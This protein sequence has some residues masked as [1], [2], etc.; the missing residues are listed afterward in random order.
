[1][2][3]K[4]KIKLIIKDFFRLAI[5]IPK[6]IIV[7]F[8][9]FLSNA[10]KGF[11]NRLRFSITFKI[12]AAF[13]LMIIS[14]FLFLSLIIV[15]GF[16]FYL[17]YNCKEDMKKDDTLI[18]TYLNNNIDSV[19]EP[20]DKIAK[21]KNRRISIFDENH[22][23]IFS[24][25]NQKDKGVYYTKD[26]KMGDG[27]EKYVIISGNKV[28]VHF[29]DTITPSSRFFIVLDESIKLD[30]TVYSI[31]YVDKLNNEFMYLGFFIS[32]LAV[33]SILALINTLITGWKAGK[34]MLKPIDNMSKT[35]KNITVNAL[36]TRINVSGSQDE[37]K[38]LAHTFNSML[39]RIQ[40]SYEQQN[41]FVSDASHELR[42]PI[43]VIQGYANL[44]DRWGKNDKDVLEE[45]I[46]A[47][48][49]EAE[50]MKGLIEQ[51]LFLARG[52]KNTQKIEK[53]NFYINELIDELIKETKLI[54]ERHKILTERNED[55]QI[56]AD[57]NLIKEALRIFIDNS[58]KYTGDGGYVKINSFKDKEKGVI[59]IEDNGIG[60]SKE[61][62]PHIFDRFY[63]ADKSRAKVSGGTGLGL[64]IAKW[65]VMKH[66]GAIEVESKIG[67]GTI[68]TLKL[69]MNNSNIV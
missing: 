2:N 50:N 58:T 31:Q 18:K 65:I 22:K 4:S 43:A 61:D 64:A 25:E 27:G 69:P 48:K 55:F 7:Q 15:A 59:T 10:R 57:R 33:I 56:S 34:R 16:G 5:I 44:L 52:D 32:G 30:S 1:M 3:N 60:I 45:S 14:F 67:E 19:Y 21:V 62:L 35:V 38:D 42:T 63:R 46:T 41:Q 6:F 8:F 51:L 68:I 29:P 40:Q 39:D 49:S 47:I 24:S 37:L 66:K 28:N 26:N 9:Q 20:I 17:G 13:V 23:L 12:T 11:I 36:D 53:T 54:N